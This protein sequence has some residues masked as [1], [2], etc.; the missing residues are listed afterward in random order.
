MMNGAMSG[1]GGPKCGVRLWAAIVKNGAAGL[2]EEV[3]FEQCLTGG[4]GLTHPC[5]CLGKEDSMQKTQPVQ[6]P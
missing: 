4:E 5:G 2:I 6:S 1:K 3:I